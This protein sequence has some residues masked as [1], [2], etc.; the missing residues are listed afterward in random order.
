MIFRGITAD[1]CNSVHN[2]FIFLHK[3]KVIGT[4]YTDTVGIRTEHQKSS[5]GLYNLIFDGYD[6]NT[7]NQLSIDDRLAAIFKSN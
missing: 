6:H 1:Q 7:K 5:H 3:L 4:V 2:L